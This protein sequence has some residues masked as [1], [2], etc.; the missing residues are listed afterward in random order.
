MGKTHTYDL[1]HGACNSPIYGQVGADE[2]YIILRAVL[3]HNRDEPARPAADSDIQFGWS[4]EHAG[5]WA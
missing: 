3:R 4:C 2:K 5:T 1:M